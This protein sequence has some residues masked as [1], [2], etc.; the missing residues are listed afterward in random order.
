MVSAQ[1]PAVEADCHRDLNE[2]DRMHGDLNTLPGPELVKL[3]N[4]FEMAL[5]RAYDARAFDAYERLR[6]RRDE[7]QELLFDL[8]W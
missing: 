7:I 1:A 5:T 3:R 2:F 6:V 4:E 8:E